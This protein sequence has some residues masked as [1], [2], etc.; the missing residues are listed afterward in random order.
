MS[1]KE[2]KKG[3]YGV[4][5]VSPALN[6]HRMGLAPLTK[7][8]WDAEIAKIDAATERQQAEIK[9]GKGEE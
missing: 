8:E 5:Y 6:L 3:R 1:K 2:D 9:K 7:E 4:F